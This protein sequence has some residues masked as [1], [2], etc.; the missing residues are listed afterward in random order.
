MNKYRVV[1]VV[2]FVV[3]LSGVFIIGHPDT[4]P[5]TEMTH[6][7][8][9]PIQLTNTEESKN[10]HGSYE[11]PAP[12]G[13]VQ[14]IKIQNRTLNPKNITVKEYD[15]ISFINNDLVAHRFVEDKKN[16]FDTGILKPGQ[17][18]YAT[19]YQ[20]VGKYTYHDTLDS[21]IKGV[22]TVVE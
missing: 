9:T 4:A 22:I 11:E 16:G 12:Q 18:I 20:K 10:S 8:T 19:M 2:S 3:I 7:V 1:I 15:I 5:H 13:T 17:S 6:M 21:A 14:E